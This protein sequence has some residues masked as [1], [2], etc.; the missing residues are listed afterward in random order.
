MNVDG[1]ISI[2][3]DPS[4]VM[5]ALPEYNDTIFFSKTDPDKKLTF[6]N[7]QEILGVS[8]T[9]GLKEEKYREKQAELEKK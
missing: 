9:H 4:Y 7:A 6:E 3:D 8:E 5:V 2:D 1:T